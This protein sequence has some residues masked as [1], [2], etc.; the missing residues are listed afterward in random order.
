MSDEP[1][2]TD[3]VQTAPSEGGDGSSRESDVRVE[4]HRPERA[5]PILDHRIELGREENARGGIRITGID[6][7]E[8]DE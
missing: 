2:P 1:S 5:E 3:P 4:P 7:S 6:D 8:H